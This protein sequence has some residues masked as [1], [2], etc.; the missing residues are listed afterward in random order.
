MIFYFLM[1]YAHCAN[2][3]DPQHMEMIPAVYQVDWCK[4]ITQFL[5][6]N[7][8][9]NKL[10]EILRVTTD[11]KLVILSVMQLLFLAILLILSSISQP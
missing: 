4:E 9:C 1:P 2:E 3:I 10:Q 6:I 7:V 11:K 8:C 5:K